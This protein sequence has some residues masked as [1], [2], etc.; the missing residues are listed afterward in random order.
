[1]WKIIINKL[2]DFQKLTIRDYCLNS[3]SLFNLSLLDHD[4]I[5]EKIKEN[6]NNDFFPENLNIYNF[7][8]NG[9]LEFIVNFIMHYNDL[10]NRWFDIDNLHK[11]KS[12]QEIY[13]SIM[14]YD[15]ES[16]FFKRMIIVP[17]ELMGNGFTENKLKTFLFLFFLPIWKKNEMLF[18]HSKKIPL[19]CLSKINNEFFDILL[20]L[21]LHLEKEEIF[22]IM[23]GKN[24]NHLLIENFMETTSKLHSFESVI[25]WEEILPIY[26]I[27][28]LLDINC[29]I[30]NIKETIPQRFLV[31]FEEIPEFLINLETKYLYEKLEQSLKVKNTKKEYVVK[32]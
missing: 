21:M 20:E 25:N 26:K 2:A 18:H 6:P 8:I 16:S 10:D 13:N 1:M 31:L 30:K 22:K 17:E 23:N 32:I 4:F 7:F 3:I 11:N 28:K 19:L 15:G 5:N 14:S 24:L 12:N 29:S 27:K 9:E